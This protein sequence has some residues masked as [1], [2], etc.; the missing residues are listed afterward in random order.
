MIFHIDLDSFFVSAERLKNP[1]L[2]GK[3]V[4]VGGRG[5]RSVISSASYE[6]RKLGV[7]SA[8]PTAQA[9]QM[10]GTAVDYAELPTGH[11]PMFSRP[12]ELAELL[13]AIGAG[14]AS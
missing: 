12:A 11:W 1:G 13:V 14:E 4:A 8:M 7:R 2:T 6:A 10:L 3:C 9:Q 5:P